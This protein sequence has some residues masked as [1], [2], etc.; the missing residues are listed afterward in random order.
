MGKSNGACPLRIGQRASPSPKRNDAGAVWQ[1]TPFQASHACRVPSRNP[2][3]AKRS[4]KR[5]CSLLLLG[6]WRPDGEHLQPAPLQVRAETTPTRPSRLLPLPRVAQQGAAWPAS[7]AVVTR[8]GQ[9]QTARGE[10]ARTGR[11]SNN[12]PITAQRCATGVPPRARRDTGAPGWTAPVPVD[13]TQNDKRASR[14]RRARYC[15][16]AR[17]AGGGD[18]ST[19]SHCERTRQIPT[20]NG[21][22]RTGDFTRLGE[23]QG[24]KKRQNGGHSFLL[25]IANS[26]QTQPLHPVQRNDLESDTRGST[27]RDAT[28]KG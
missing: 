3:G 18:R 17:W 1:C 6:C 13:R 21:T 20:C 16:P 15:H 19:P 27:A 10:V 2:Y 11:N 28:L 22:R 5:V 9:T 14:V 25:L 4:S 23:P 8:T 26:G 12:M 24:R 7:E